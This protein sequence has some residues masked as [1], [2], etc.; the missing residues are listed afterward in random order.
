MKIVDL[1]KA[2]APKAKQKIIG[3]RPGEKVHEQMIG[4]EDAFS[5]YIYKDYF[6]IL[7]LINDWNEDKKRIKDGKKVNES[8]S[9]NSRDN[10]EWMTKKELLSWLKA[11]EGKIGNI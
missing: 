11:N 6:K 3:I 5:T 7:P 4:V 1:A 9:Y 8:F 10:S 2:I